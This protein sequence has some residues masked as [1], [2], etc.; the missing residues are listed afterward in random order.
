MNIEQSMVLLNWD[1]L[2][3]ITTPFVGVC[4]EVGCS[5]CRDLNEMKK[6]MSGLSKLERKSSIG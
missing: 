1:L 4:I 3:K 2:E 5:S 6:V